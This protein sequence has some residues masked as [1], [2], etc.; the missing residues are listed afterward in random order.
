MDIQG[1]FTKLNA[2]SQTVFEQSIS[3]KET[4]GKLHHL[5]SCI[6]E[7]SNVLRDPQEKEF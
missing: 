7:M 6:Y 2:E 1:Y 4:L 3:Q 5:S